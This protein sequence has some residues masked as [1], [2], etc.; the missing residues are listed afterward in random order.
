ML[1]VYV[2][3][4]VHLRWLVE[5]QDRRYCVCIQRY[6]DNTEWTSLGQIICIVT[7]FDL[8]LGNFRCCD[9]DRLEIANICSRIKVYDKFLDL[10]WTNSYRAWLD[11]KRWISACRWFNCVEVEFEREQ[12]LIVTLVLYDLK[13]K[14]ISIHFLEVFLVKNFPINLERSDTCVFDFESLSD[15]TSVC[16]DCWHWQ[17]RRHCVVVKTYLISR[18]DHWAARDVN[19][20][21]ELNSWKALHVAD[22]LIIEFTADVVVNSHHNRH[23]GICRKLC[24]MGGEDQRYTLVVAQVE[25]LLFLEYFSLSES[26]SCCWTEFLS[27]FMLIRKNWLGATL[28]ICTIC[29]CARLNRSCKFDLAFVRR[30][31][32]VMAHRIF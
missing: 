7:D 13:L 3:A 1:D 8:F 6:S 22:N 16:N 27:L 30:F 11:L 17:S 2:L 18:D 32:A 20:H 12:L 10:T 28:I 9:D 24:F 19:P 5:G 26:V 31:T 29:E 14:C 4:S 15:L 21:R 23:F 25:L